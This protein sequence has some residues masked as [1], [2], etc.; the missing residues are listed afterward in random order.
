MGDCVNLERGSPKWK[1]ENAKLKLRILHLSEEMVL[2]ELEKLHNQPKPL[3]KDDTEYL[4]EYLKLKEELEEA[5]YLH[6]DY[7]VQYWDSELQG[8]NELSS[9]L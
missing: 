4:Q 3:T 1:F 9:L 8:R 6:M 5:R 2:E 7:I